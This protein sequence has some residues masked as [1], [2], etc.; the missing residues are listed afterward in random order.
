M[1]NMN[2][3][4]GHAKC[5]HKLP[6]YGI[7]MCFSFYVSEN[8]ILSWVKQGKF[9]LFLRPNIHFNICWKHVYFIQG[10][11]KVYWHRHHNQGKKQPTPPKWKTPGETEK[12][13]K[14]Y[15]LT[16][17]SITQ[18]PLLWEDFFPSFTKSCFHFDWDM[19]LTKNW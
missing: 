16:F 2:Q 15:F 13:N 12:R 8:C 6:N 18:L 11:S 19:L 9:K 10:Q 17:S 1:S 7:M 14:S 3:M 4:K 5:T